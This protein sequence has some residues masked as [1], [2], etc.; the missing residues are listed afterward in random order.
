MCYKAFAVEFENL[1][2]CVS[3]IVESTF[4]GGGEVASGFFGLGRSS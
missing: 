2:S 4:L 1:G 3:V